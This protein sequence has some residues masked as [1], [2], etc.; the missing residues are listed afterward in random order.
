MCAQSLQP[1]GLYSLPSSSVHGIFQARNTGVGCH[2]L[3]QGSSRPR[4]QNHV[5]CTSCNGRSSLYH[6]H[7]LGIRYLLVNPQLAS[8][9]T[10]AAPPCHTL[11]HPSRGKRIASRSIHVSPSSSPRPQGKATSCPQSAPTSSPTVTMPGFH[12]PPKEALPHPAPFSTRGGTELLI[13]LVHF[14]PATYQ[15]CCGYRAQRVQSWIPL[16]SSCMISSTLVSLSESQFPYLSRR[17]RGV[18]TYW[19]I[20]GQFEQIDEHKAVENKAPWAH[21][22]SGWHICQLWEPWRQDRHSPCYNPN[23]G[24][25]AKHILDK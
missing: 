5:S 1:C 10:S 13:Y 18:P 25:S 3:L 21:M 6:L 15:W 9:Q 7:Y 11:P 14:S 24:V 19:A 8:T 16:L 20:P 22:H 4:N 17:I 23:T 12:P 2:F